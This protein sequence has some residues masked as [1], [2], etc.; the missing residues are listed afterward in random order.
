MHTCLANFPDNLLEVLKTRAN[1]SFPPSF[2]KKLN[3]SSFITPKL[4]KIIKRKKGRAYT[5]D[6][7]CQLKQSVVTKEQPKSRF[8]S[9]M[10][11]GT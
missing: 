5:Q 6:E 3:C 11:E 1:Y 7:K 8:Y 2:R 9:V 10:Y 4:E